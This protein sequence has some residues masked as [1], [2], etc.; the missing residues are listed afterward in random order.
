MGLCALADSQKQPV[1]KHVAGFQSFQTLDGNATSAITVIHEIVM[2]I[3]MGNIYPAVLYMAF[4]Q[5]RAFAFV[6]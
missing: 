1:L 5:M 4:N 6:R 3:K 2:A